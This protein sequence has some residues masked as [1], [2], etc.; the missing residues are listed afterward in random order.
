MEHWN[1]LI[2]GFVL[3]NLSPEEYQELAQILAENPHLNDEVVR[4]RRTATIRGGRNNMSVPLWPVNISAAGAQGWADTAT[5]LIE[6]GSQELA[7]EELDKGS[8]EVLRRDRSPASIK[9]LAFE[10]RLRQSRESLDEICYRRLKLWGWILLLAVVALS[11]DDWRLRRSLA[12]AQEK[13]MQLEIRLNSASVSDE[14]PHLT[15]RN[16]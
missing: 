11:I 9:N 4:L 15:S 12:I 13:I 8:K 3:G 14:A 7:S 5:T 16:K 1:E 6:L 10:R 2:A